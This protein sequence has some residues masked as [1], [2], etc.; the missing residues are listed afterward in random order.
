VILRRPCR[1]FPRSAALPHAGG[2][3]KLTAFFDETL[4][5]RLQKSLQIRLVKTQANVSSIKLC[6]Q[7]WTFFR[8][9]SKFKKKEEKCRK[10][11]YF[12]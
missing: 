8:E 6:M 3:G 2:L 10:F 9:Q 11:F 1:F 12:N 4:K 7:F 5:S